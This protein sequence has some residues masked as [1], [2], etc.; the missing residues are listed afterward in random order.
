MTARQIFTRCRQV[1]TL[2]ALA[3]AAVGAG[4]QTCALPG[5]DGPVTPAGVVNTY[6]G[7]SGSPGAGATS[8]TVSSLA[9]LRTN[10]RSLRVG[11]MVL[12]MQ[13]QDSAT[14]AN[15]GRHEY[16]QIVAIAGSTLAL[17][18]P[19]TNSYAQ[20]MGIANVRNWQVVWVPQYSA[21]TINGTVSADRW[22]INTGSGVAT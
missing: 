5:W 14:P 6:H 22:N 3:G 10:T 7:G 18:R 4:A 19:L 2:L 11:D 20:N 15:A 17:N 12:I 1:L 9:G 13:M 8:I 16:A 21:A